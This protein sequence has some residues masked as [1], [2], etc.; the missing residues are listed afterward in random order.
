MSR[1]ATAANAQSRSEAEADGPLLEVEDLRVQFNTDAGVVRAVNGVSFTVAAGE[2]LA[3]VGESGSGKSVTGMSLLGLL[4]KPAAETSGIVRWKGKDLVGASESRLRK[5]RGGEISMIF[6]DAMTSLNPVMTVGRQITE[7]IGL[8]T[9]LKGRAARARAVEMLDAVGIPQASRRVG[10]YPHE[11]SGGMRQRA[12]IAMAIACDPQLIIA[13]EPT[14]ALDVTVQA[15]V[16]EVLAEIQERTGA[17]MILIT[18]DLGVVAGVA[19]RVMVMY[20]GRQVETAVTD[21]VFYDTRHPYTLGLMA[22][23][24]RVDIDGL[25]T[26]A[27]GGHRLKPIEGQPPS[28]LSLPS[29]CAFHPRCEMAGLPEP[30][31]TEVPELLQIR[32]GHLSACHFADRLGE[33]AREVG[34]DYV[35][36][37]EAPPTP[38]AASTAAPAGQEAHQ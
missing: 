10:S 5:V 6:Q 36:I 12:M 1:T 26:A 3:L 28:L 15:Q 19:D 31:A 9:S 35:E 2:T 14:T 33:R 32:S 7:M 25:M 4:P 8:H 16:L 34:S 38:V 37:V 18:H 13:D 20:A 11:F 22:S 29:G 17:G 27:D 24:P 23:L 30:C 21:E